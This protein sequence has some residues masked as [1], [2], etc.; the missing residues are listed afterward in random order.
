MLQP[1]V[2][3]SQRARHP[4]RS[5]SPRHRV[6]GPSG[7]RSGRCPLPGVGWRSRQNEMFFRSRGGSKRKQDMPDNTVKETRPFERKSLTILNVSMVPL[8]RT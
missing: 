3:A 6:P 5:E 2:Q 7:D 8:S 4:G 1:V